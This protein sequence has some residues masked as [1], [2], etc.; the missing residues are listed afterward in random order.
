MG[1]KLVL[2]FLILFFLCGCSNNTG[3]MFSKLSSL[4]T[5]IHFNNVVFENDTINPIDIEYM[6]NGGGVATGDFNNDGLPDLYFTANLVSNKL[7]L[8]EGKMKFRDVSETAN[9]KGQG[10]WSNGASVID[11]NND[12]LLDIYVCTSIKQNASQR[13]NLLYVNQGINENKIPVFKE[14]AHEYGLADTSYSVQAAFFDYDNDG[15]LDIYLLNTKLAKRQAASFNSGRKKDSIDFDKLYRN[16]W[17]KELGHPIFTDVSPEAGINI[18]GYGLGVAVVDINKDGWKDIYV[19]NDFYTSDELYINNHNG[20]FTNRIK[21]YFKHTSLN[22]MG[23]D[24]GDLNNDGLD[25]ILALDMNPE[26]NYRKKK[27][28]GNNNY[29]VYQSLS[30]QGFS[31]QYVRNTLQLNMGPRV[32]SNDSLG[33]PIFSEV[34]FLA[35]IAETDWSWTPSIADFDNDGQKDIIIT[36]GYPRDITDHDFSMFRKRLINIASKKLLTDPIP[37]IKIPNYAFKNRGNLQFDNVTDSWGF[38][39]PSFS[40]G[41]VYV[42]LDLDGD[43][44]YVINNINEEASIYLNNTNTNE[45]IKGNYLTISFKGDSLN[46]N[47]IG[48]LV[49]VYA[50]H[51]KQTYE[52]NPYRGYLATVDNKAYFGLDTIAIADSV[53]VRWQSGMKQVLANVKANRTILAD[54]ANANTRDPY[55]KNNFKG[56][57]LTEVTSQLGVNY[58]HTENDVSDFNKERLLPHKLSEYGPALATG[59]IDGNGLDDMIIG[60][61]NGNVPTCLLQQ[62]NGTFMTRQLYTNS[63]NAAPAE[64]MGVLL[65][66]ADN[67]GDL[68]VYLVSGSN[69]FAANAENYQDKLLIN[70]G[71]GNFAFDLKAIPKNYVSKSCVKASDID[72][73]GDLDLFIGGRVLPGQY[74]LPVSSFIYRNDS[75]KGKVIFTDITSTAAKMLQDIGMV[76]DASFTDFDNDGQNDLIIAGEWMP[77]TF[78]KNDK[79]VFINVTDK[80][81]INKEIGWWN[82]IA[83]G[84]FDNDGDIDYVVG[85]LGRNSFYRASHKYPASVYAKDFDHNGS[86]DAIPVIFMKDSLGEFREYTT[87]NRDDIMEQ[88]PGLKKRYLSYK[89]FAE[90]DIYDLISKESLNDALVL[91]ATNFNSCYIEN[92]GG[93][94]FRITPL[95]LMAQVAPVYGI[96]CEDFNLDGNLDIALVGNDFGTEVGTGRYDAMNGL[97]LSGNGHGNFAALSIKD[98]GMFVPGNAKALIKLKGTNNQMLLAASQNR[99]ALKIFRSAKPVNIITASKKDKFFYLTTKEGK[100]R[101]QEIYYGSSFLSQSSQFVILN[102]AIIEAMVVTKNGVQKSIK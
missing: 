55:L 21:D 64:N 47:G 52:N 35:G 84:D 4:Q 31:L 34:G 78:L 76:C 97:V 58:V 9:V 17:S 36:N 68:D 90:A 40:N 88:I 16:D 1:Q 87:H 102:D 82:S 74:P 89:S 10:E 25:D 65:F 33:E 93:G 3:K 45:R 2:I 5:N 11:I 43:L 96:V 12:G 39:D 20:T 71:K 80:T 42:D 14:M 38:D 28:L 29:F 99:D 48:T 86:M 32:N 59:D 95:P 24:V 75:E 56:I 67:D 27:N 66:D 23:N 57:L 41:A 94:K 63:G 98:A 6:Y 51:S 91:K 101:K 50:G 30:A 54:I 13:R 92:T 61:A 8:N 85:N 62:V 46:K 72:N 44:D 73:D 49:E 81:G 60:A 77:I 18:S 22:A 19:T 26:N 69:E 53:V 37:Q 70:D 100:T 15:D 83:G 7:Y 79:G